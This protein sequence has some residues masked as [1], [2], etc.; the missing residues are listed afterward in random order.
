M[1]S[2]S[3][4][5]APTPLITKM[6]VGNADSNTASTEALTSPQEHDGDAGVSSLFKMAPCEEKLVEEDMPLSSCGAK[7]MDD[8]QRGAEND[9]DPMG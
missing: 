5:A 3:S 7:A 4:K 2:S 8:A 9:N 6:P 1:A